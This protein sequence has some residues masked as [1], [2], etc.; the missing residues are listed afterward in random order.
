M[1]KA[2]TILAVAGLSLAVT[3]AR[4]DGFVIVDNDSKED[5]TQMFHVG[6]NDRLYVTSSSCATFGFDADG[7][8]LAG[9]GNQG[10]FTESCWGDFSIRPDNTFDVIAA[11]GANMEVRSASAALVSTSAPFLPALPSGYRSMGITHLL[12]LADGKFFG[13]GNAAVDCQVCLQT[14]W[15]YTR[16]NA[17]ATVDAG[18]ANGF[19]LLDKPNGP[20]ENPILRS[21]LQQADG[22]VIEATS[23]NGVQTRL[24]RFDSSGLDFTFGLNARTD[25]AGALGIAAQDVSGRIYVPTFDGTIVRVN[26]NG[27]IDGTYSAG[28]A[29]PQLHIRDIAIDSSGRAVLFGTRVIAVDVFEAYVARF[30][31]N[32]APDATFNGGSATFQ[33]TRPIYDGGNAGRYGCRGLLQS[34]DRPVLACTVHAERDTGAA[35]NIN[36]ALLRFTSAGAI[37]TTFGAV[38]PDSD[39]YPDDVDFPDATVA[40]G[41]IG[42]VS[43]PVTVSGI[44]PGGRA[45]IP[46]GDFSIGCNGTW[47]TSG[48]ISNG[49]TICAR[50]NASSTPGATTTKTL[51]IGGRLARFNIISTNVPA[52]SIP[53]AFT[54]AAQNNVAVS[55]EV[56]SA[57]ITVSGITGYSTATATG[58]GGF[59]VDCA[60]PVRTSFAQITNGTTLCARHTSSAQ[61]ATATS[62]TLNVGGVSSTFISTTLAADTTP[63]AFAFT[64]QSGVAVN[65]VSTS[66]AVIIGGINAPAA[67]SVSGGEYSVGCSTYTSAAGTVSSGQTV[68]VRHTSAATTSTTVTTTVTIGGVAATFS[69]TTAAAS[70][71][72]SSGGGG[73]GSLDPLWLAALGVLALGSVQA[74]R[75]VRLPTR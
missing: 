15:I 58:S 8:L 65:S 25:V 11:T 43:Q 10:K 29:T 37:D 32:G 47:L 34:G 30:D 56:T 71:S 33:F 46:S 9:F 59:L 62:T 66:A 23:L 53:D 2:F 55:T 64:G 40:Y 57:P 38:T 16:L 49:Q 31:T 74:R 12:R 61:F 5:E 19:L 4:A 72:S 44:E 35:S 1:N 70:S 18:F 68:C 54:L 7:N 75:R 36:I 52:D 17:D 6:P 67:I 41:S 69:S 63:D 51:S 14:D 60:G 27:V 73:G 28:V 24:Q 21:L 50:G 20:G 3:A 22:K 39:L 45:A 26:A 42:V 48:Y 13:A